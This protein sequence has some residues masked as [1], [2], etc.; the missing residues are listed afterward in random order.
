MNRPYQVFACFAVSLVLPLAAMGQDYT[1]PERRVSFIEKLLPFLFEEEDTGPKPEDT[2]QAPF[3]SS[4]TDMS[5][6]GRMGLDYKPSAFEELKVSLDQPHRQ[7]LQ[8]SAWASG[9]VSEALSVDPLRYESHMQSLGGIMTPYAQAA[10]KAYLEKDRLLEAVKSNSLVM[11]AFVDEPARVLNQGTLQGRY[12]WLVETPV[13][14]S[15]LPRD[16]IDY[17]T[18]KPKNRRLQ[19]RT[20]IGRVETGGVDGVIIETIEFVPVVEKKK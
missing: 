14:V 2:L 3:S 10:L 16:T 6:A 19:A 18:L 17:E 8:V 11:R 1:P 5:T 4:A 12:R 9:A 13:T 20:Q 7:P 15:F